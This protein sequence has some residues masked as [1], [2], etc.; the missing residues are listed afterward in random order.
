M[1]LKPNLNNR[2]W[3]G[4]TVIKFTKTKP[5]FKMFIFRTKHLKMIYWTNS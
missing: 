2:N 3:I 1:E 5:N 4:V